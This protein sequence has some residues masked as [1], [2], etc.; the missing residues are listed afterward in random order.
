MLYKYFFFIDLLHYNNEKSFNTKFLYNYYKMALFFKRKKEEKRDIE[1]PHVTGIPRFPEF[2]TK[3]PEIESI[4]KEIERKPEDLGIPMREVIQTG[5][6]TKENIS[7]PIRKPIQEEKV[8]V[9][10]RS[11]DETKPIFVKI[12]KYKT[13][14]DLIDQIKSR[15]SEAEKILIDIENLK[16]NEDKELENW[17]SELQEIKEKLLSVDKNLFEV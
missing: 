10:R 3:F 12:E 1:L 5:Q 2:P 4:K 15:I 14:I 7:I 16:A 8:M 11:P 17:K 13:A 6:I 9:S